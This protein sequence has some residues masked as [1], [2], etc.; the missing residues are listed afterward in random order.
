MFHD[1]YNHYLEIFH[2]FPPVTS[3]V[4]LFRRV[5]WLEFEVVIVAWKAAMVAW[6]SAPL[7]VYSVMRG[8]TLA[9]TRLFTATV[10]HVHPTRNGAL[11][12]WRNR[13]GVPGVWWCGSEKEERCA[14]AITVMNLR[15]ECNV[16]N[17]LTGWT[18]FSFSR[19]SLL[20][21]VS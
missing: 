21:R 4:S 20:L 19:T 1:D 10:I 11:G 7:F 16:E 14:F 3:C 17:I 5:I 18:T 6:S 12:S 13:M 2:D 9:K 8:L 15:I